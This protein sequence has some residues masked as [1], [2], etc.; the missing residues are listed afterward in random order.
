MRLGVGGLNGPAAWQLQRSLRMG[1]RSD[2]W[3]QSGVV[4]RISASRAVFRRS[5]GSIS[6][7]LAGD[8]SQESSRYDVRC[9]TAAG[10]LADGFG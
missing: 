6:S 9:P 7:S 10:M 5:F 3:R 1:R 4:S 2:T 8:I